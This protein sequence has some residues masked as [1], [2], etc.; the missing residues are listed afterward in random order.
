VAGIACLIQKAQGVDVAWG[1][2]DA[3]M[4]AVGHVALSSKVFRW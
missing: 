1:L 4:Y 2:N 3:Q